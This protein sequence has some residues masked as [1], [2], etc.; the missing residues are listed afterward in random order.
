M[1]VQSSGNIIIAGDIFPIPENQQAFC[2]GNVELLLGEKLCNLFSSAD[3]VVC[4][5]EGALTDHDERCVKTG[6]VKVAPTRAVEAF[7]KMGVKCCMLANNHA[8]DGGHQGLLDTMDALQQAGIQYIG[9]GKDKRSITKSVVY[10]VGGM[11]VGFYNVSE[12][13]YNKPTEMV[14]GAWLY[15]EYV[16]CHDIEALRKECDYLVVI[17]H[18][19]IEKFPY[20]S[21][22]MRKRFHRMADSG[23]DMVLSQHTHCI[24]SEENYN[25]SY[26][27]YGQGDF[28][29]KNFK[30]G[31]T[32]TGLLVELAI[33]DGRVEVR[34][35]KVESVDDRYVRYAANQDLSDFMHRSSRIGDEDFVDQEFRNFCKGELRLYLAAFKSPGWL[36]Q[37]FRRFFPG[38][39]RRWLFSDA[40]TDR[41]LLF[42]LHTLRSEQNRETAIVGI[43]DLLDERKGKATM[44]DVK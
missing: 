22:E 42:A 1:V 34:K 38:A 41:N 13:M 35:H 20:P 10:E 2:D 12:T 8:T 33:Q 7:E 44:A 18:G 23:A 31:Q 19:G 17:Y 4:N 16:V 24:G 11:K 32:D 25:G 14:A 3:L 27:L 43:E 36:R 37:R 21:P 28:L 40:Y 26:L 15:D 5:L 6:P 29:L 30:P 9:A 39:F